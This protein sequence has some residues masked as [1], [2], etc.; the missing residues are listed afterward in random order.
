MRFVHTS[1]WQ[2]GKTFRFADAA[3]DR[4]RDE[5][6]QV[7]GRLGQLAMAQGAQAVLVA[8]DVYDLHT[9][10]ELTLRQPIERMRAFPGI[11]WYLIPGNH[12][13]HSPRGP[14]DRLARTVLPA[15]IHPVMAAEPVEMAGGAFLLPAVLT[16]RHAATDPTAPMDAMATPPGAP[17]IGLAHGSIASFGTDDSLTPNRIAPDRDR[18]AGLSYLALGDWHGGQRI[19]PRCWYSGT[20]EVDDFSIKDGGGG[21]A[22]VVD[23]HGGAA[24]EP[25][26]SVHATGRFDWRKEEATLTG[27]A[28]IEAL[29]SRLRQGADLGNRLLWLTVRGA[30]TLAERDRFQDRIALGLDS[31]LCVLR[32]EAEGLLA[33]PDAADLAA[34]DDAGFLGAA[35]GALA[36]QAEDAADPGRAVAAA[37]LQR[38]YVL[39][40]QARGA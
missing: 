18:L 31:A 7:I 3:A 36:R 35:A 22:L 34:F 5:R 29:E 4:L 27:G 33:R 21:Q 16:R 37:A 2:V 28:D 17:R 11:H 23:L 8:G 13:P 30:L 25:A 20:P 32:L 1:D 26:V 15:N 14:W 40:R 38:L 6:L 19:G 12:D 39:H 10:S 24:G 9:P